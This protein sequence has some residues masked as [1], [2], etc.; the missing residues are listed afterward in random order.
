MPTLSLQG[1]VCVPLFLFTFVLS[2][3]ITTPLFAQDLR[4]R[5]A[6]I[7]H[8]GRVII[9]SESLPDPVYE[10]QKNKILISVLFI[11][12][13]SDTSFITSVGTGFVTESPGT[14][15]TARHLLDMSILDAEKYKADKLKSDPKFDYGYVFMG[16]IITDKEWLNFPLSLV[17][18]GE[19]GTLRD[20]MAL[21]VDTKTMENAQM[22]GD[23]FFQNPL[24]LLMKTSK[25]AD[26][27]IGEKVYISGYS[28]SV[29]EYLDKNNKLVPVYADFIDHTF[30][31][32]TEAIITDMPINKTGIKVMYRLRDH[33]EPGFSGGKVL[34]AQGHVIGMT[35]ASS[36]S[37]NFIYVLS[38]KDIRD[39]LKEN[40]LK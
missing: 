31:A 5:T 22:I 1:S 27:D 33:A 21:R 11:A 34:N 12:K 2:Q 40:K 26:A 13:G 9:S 16:T 35:I 38:S 24:R 25:F 20:I 10:A 19:K 3:L 29:S 32:E 36:I 18:V 17:A 39:F 28:P 7:F 14:I 6:D 37:K 23:S 8:M 4:N 15:V 30:I